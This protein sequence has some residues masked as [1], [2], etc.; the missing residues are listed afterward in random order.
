MKNTITQNF[1]EKTKSMGIGNLV[2]ATALSVGVMVTWDNARADTNDCM[3]WPVVDYSLTVTT[4]EGP[5][6]YRC[7]TPEELVSNIEETDDCMSWPVID[8]SLTETTDEG[9]IPYRCVDKS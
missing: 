9:P 1:E 8:Y 7:A 4:D 5:V 3:S 2:A 6:P